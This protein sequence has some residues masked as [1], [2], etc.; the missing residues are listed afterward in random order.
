MFQRNHAAYIDMLHKFP[1]TNHQ[2][3]Q[4]GWMIDNGAC[5]LNLLLTW[6]NRSALRPWMN[7]VNAYLKSVSRTRVRYFQNF[8]NS[9]H[10]SG[11]HAFP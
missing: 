1:V 3:A 11:R 7:G 5:H 4:Y 6:L 10:N 8:T 2:L 9:F